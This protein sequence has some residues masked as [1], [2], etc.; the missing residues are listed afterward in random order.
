[1]IPVH[2]AWWSLCSVYVSTSQRPFFMLLIGASLW[3]WE[4]VLGSWD[5]VRGGSRCP[6]SPLAYTQISVLECCCVV[7]SMS[8]GDD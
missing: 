7:V 5:V 6:W 2:P 1:M 8:T 4:N 3:L